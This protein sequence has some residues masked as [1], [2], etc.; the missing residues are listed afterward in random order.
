MH[1]TTDY[2]E[3]VYEKV[4]DLSDRV[5]LLK[6][7]LATQTCGVRLE[8]YWE[9]ENIRSSFAEFK[10]RLDQLGDDHRDQEAFESAWTKLAY[11]ID[12][13]LAAL[14]EGYSSK[15]RCQKVLS[16]CSRQVC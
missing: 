6:N 16:D 15:N 9:L 2:R 14:P 1:L 7:R 5:A 13:L 12:N 10:W 11:A 3:V 4:D 8:H